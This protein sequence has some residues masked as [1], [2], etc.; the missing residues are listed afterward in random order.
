MGDGPRG[1][2]IFPDHFQ[3][4]TSGI[5]TPQTITSRSEKELEVFIIR[6]TYINYTLNISSIFLL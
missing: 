6:G 2:E 3:A 1:I 5:E 4:S